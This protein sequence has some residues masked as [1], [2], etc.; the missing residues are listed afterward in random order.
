MIDD[1]KERSVGQWEGLTRTEIEA[2]WPGWIDGDQRPEGW[3]HE[4]ELQERVLKAF[5]TIGERH[6]GATVLVIAHGGVL[7]AMEKILGV[8]E[9]RIPN[10]HG[11]VFRWTDGRF[12]AGRNS[13]S[14]P[15]SCARAGAASVTRLDAESETPSP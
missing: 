10:L 13:T 4:P 6:P 12:V 2:E 15:T 7:I 11:R 14:Y 5:T 8:N 9:A 3:E 1:L